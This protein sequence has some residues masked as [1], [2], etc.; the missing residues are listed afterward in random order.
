M[1]V[2][3][4]VVW[5]VIS[6]LVVLVSAGCTGFN[7]GE[8]QAG[9]AEENQQIQLKLSQTLVVRLDANITTGYSWEIVKLDGM[10]RSSGEPEYQAPESGSPPRVGAGGSQVFRFQATGA[11]SADLQL[12]YRRPWEKDTP[13]ARTYH[14]TVIVKE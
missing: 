1:I 5:F 8:V 11:G 4:K 10:L 14:L 13:P 2:H 7:P 12:A 6:L 3:V 9:A